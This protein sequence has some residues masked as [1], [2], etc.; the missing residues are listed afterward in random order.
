MQ[1]LYV[2]TSFDDKLIEHKPTPQMWR[3]KVCRKSY[4]Y[5]NPATK[6]FHAVLYRS[7]SHHNRCLL[8]V[9]GVVFLQCMLCYMAD[10]TIISLVQASWVIYPKIVVD[11]SWTAYVK[12]PDVFTYTSNTTFN[13]LFFLMAAGCCPEPMWM[14]WKHYNWCSTSKASI[15]GE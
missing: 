12:L 10:F 15:H 3:S 1:I 11:I 6:N 5:C 2:Y 9:D 4:L 13:L 14:W 8:Q 7:W